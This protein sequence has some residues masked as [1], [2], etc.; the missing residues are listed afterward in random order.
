MK[1]IRCSG[2]DGGII[3]IN[4]RQILWVREIESGGCMIGLGL[5]A[6][7]PSP[8]PADKLLTLIEAAEKS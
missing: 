4:V 2:S 5:G 1:F 7:I 6:E 8:E 3:H